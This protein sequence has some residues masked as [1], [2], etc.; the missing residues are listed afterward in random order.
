LPGESFAGIA[1]FGEK[2][3]AL[4][5]RFRPFADGTPSHDHLG[6]IFAHRRRGSLP[7][8]L[9]FLPGMGKLS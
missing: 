1:Q 9:C 5:R 4:L 7:A 8:L 2:K 3:V 6:D